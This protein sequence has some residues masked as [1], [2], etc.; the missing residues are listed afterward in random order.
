MLTTSI[1]QMPKHMRQ[2]AKKKHQ[3]SIIFRQSS[4]AKLLMFRK[5]LF[6]NRKLSKDNNLNKKKSHVNNNSPKLNNH[7]FSNCYQNKS[8]GLQE[9]CFWWVAPET[10]H[11][12][13]ILQ[14]KLTYGQINL[15]CPS[16][17]Q[18]EWNF[19]SIIQ[20][21]NWRLDEVNGQVYLSMCSRV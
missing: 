7:Y 4:K 8:I 17:G 2:V 5:K 18:K 12:F 20:W 11:F 3:W 9:I 1:L 19:G 13:S 15:H 21:S 16:V 14:S 10:Y 6:F